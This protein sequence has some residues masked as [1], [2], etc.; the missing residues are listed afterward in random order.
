MKLS[1]KGRLADFVR[2]NSETIWKPSQIERLLNLVSE[3]EQKNL[4]RGLKKLGA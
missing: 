4:I 1:D 3:I 2:E